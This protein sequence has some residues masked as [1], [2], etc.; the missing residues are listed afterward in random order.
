MTLLSIV[1]AFGI[2]VILAIA[3]SRS[4]SARSVAKQ[5]L[6]GADSDFGE[7]TGH[8]HRDFSR[9][10]LDRIFSPDDQAFVNGLGSPELRCA[11]T[12]ERKCLAIRWIR[13]NAFE[14]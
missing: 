10:I 3:L 12:A 13:S 4:T 2:F 1:A 6:F 7:E 9:Q 14:A 5:S 8:S 11:L